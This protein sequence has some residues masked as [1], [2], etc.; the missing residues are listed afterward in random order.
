MGYG[1]GRKPVLTRPDRISERSS[2][3]L[4]LALAPALARG[5]DLG[6]VSIRTFGL[7]AR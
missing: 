7:V 5:I 4:P 6:N 1:I 3:A 2:R